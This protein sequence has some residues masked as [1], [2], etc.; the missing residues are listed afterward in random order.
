[1][2]QFEF[3]GVMFIFIFSMVS[4]NNGIVNRIYDLVGY[5]QSDFLNNAVRSYASI[6]HAEDTQN[7][8]KKV[9]ECIA[10]NQPYTLEYRILHKDDYRF[11]RPFRNYISGISYLPPSA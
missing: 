3:G 11:H 1:M 2:A 4:I 10:A 5:P 7:I 9:Q 8:T 6:M